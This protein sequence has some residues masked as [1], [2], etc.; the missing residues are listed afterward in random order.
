[1]V[2][3]KS[4]F[5]GLK[6]LISHKSLISISGS[7]GTGK[8]SL[9][10][11]LIGNLLGDNSSCV[12]IQASESF[13]NKRFDI[14]FKHNLEKLKN[15][16]EKIFVTPARGPCTTFSEQQ[17]ILKK[18][19]NKHR[20]NPPD[21]KYI[22]IDNISHHLRYHIAN[23]DDI[24]LRNSILNDFFNTQLYPLIMFSHNHNIKLFLIH[25]M[26]YN[27][28]LGK[29]LRFF[30]KMYERI[31]SLGLELEEDLFSKKK[32]MVIR[33][34]NSSWTTNYSLENEGFR[35]Y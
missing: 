8:T 4:V 29:N 21:L 3:Q 18:I 23:I 10:E 2:S 12:W 25:E 17:Q 31:D 9:A 35:W 32:K 7:S 26:S 28:D 13:P 16:K 1:M 33:A 11:F 15:I 6:K 30:N 19:V 34:N 27:P 20:Y 24:R 5:N 14:M 22:V